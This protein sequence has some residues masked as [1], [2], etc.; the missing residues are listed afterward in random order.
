[1][2]FLE[3]IEVGEVRDLGSHTFTAEDIKRFASAYDPQPFHLDEAAAADSPY[4]ALIASGWH[5]VAVWMR[6]NVRDLQRGERERRDA[7][8]AFAQSG[9]SPGFNDLK[10]LKPVFAG[11]T[12]TYRSEVV[13]RRRSR[14]RPGWGLIAIRNSGRNQHGEEVMS[15]IGHAFVE[16]RSQAEEEG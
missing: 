2:K 1:M 7:G 3:E 6:L 8:L 14:S 15:F 5:T 12:I 10:W 4:G 16:A 9:P 11:D 13:E